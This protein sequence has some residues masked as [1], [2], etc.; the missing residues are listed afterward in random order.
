MP[1]FSFLFFLLLQPICFKILCVSSNTVVCNTW[2][3]TSSYLSDCCLPLISKQS[4]H[5]P[6]TSGIHED[7]LL[8]LLRFFFFLPTQVNTLYFCTVLHKARTAESAV[9]GKSPRISSFWNT[10]WLAAPGTVP[11]SKPF[12]SPLLPLI[13]MLALNCTG[14]TSWPHGRNA[15][16]RCHEIW[17]R[18][19]V[20]NT[21]NCFVLQREILSWTFQCLIEPPGRN[22]SQRWRLHLNAFTPAS[23]DGLT[24]QVVSRV[25]ENKSETKLFSPSHHCL[26]SSKIKT[27]Q[28]PS[29]LWTA[30]I[31]SLRTL[32]KS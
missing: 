23:C 13:V 2:A 10:A 30:G 9:C 17:I 14:T 12:E 11:R 31:Q 5:S 19:R 4:G 25:F 15:L 24:A 27:N 21:I 26:K 29:V 7:F 1:Y 28:T 32:C 20:K 8:F 6:P 16:S 3:V 18:L 22:V